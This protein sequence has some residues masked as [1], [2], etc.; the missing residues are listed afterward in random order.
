VS[1]L[2]FALRKYQGLG[3]ATYLLLAAVALIVIDGV[4][5]IGTSLTG[6]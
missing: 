3:R 5:L 2:R 4:A 6:R 1:C